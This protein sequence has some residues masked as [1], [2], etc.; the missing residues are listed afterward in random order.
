MRENGPDEFDV[1]TK[2]AK[3]PECGGMLVVRV[4]GWGEIAPDLWEPIVAQLQIDCENEDPYG[5]Y[6][7]RWWQSDWQPVV[8]RV[9]EWALR[10][11]PKRR[12]EDLEKN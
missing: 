12:T 5:W 8:D 3:C 4:N 6:T 9:R 11:I 1:P 2:V 7:H 10:R